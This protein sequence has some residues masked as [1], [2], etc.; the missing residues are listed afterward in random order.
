MA[1]K[2]EMSLAVAAATGVLVYGIF[3][4]ELPSAADVHAA[5]AHNPFIRN[6]VNVAGWSS[7]AAVAGIS[8]LAK[9]PTVFVVGGAL[10]A[11]LTWRFKHASMVS[12]GT[13]QVTLPP[14]NGQP[15]PAQGQQTGQ[16]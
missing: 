7:A 11:F 10:A 16:G 3:T 4:V 15:A 12:P 2:P 9:D 6:S 8:L 5:P 13:G 1:L 14:Q